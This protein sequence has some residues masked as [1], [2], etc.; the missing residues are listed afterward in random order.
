MIT[1]AC[2]GKGDSIK[3]ERGDPVE[4][5]DCITNLKDGFLF[6][7]RH[8]LHSQRVNPHLY[9]LERWK[10]SAGKRI[11]EISKL[12]DKSGALSWL[13]LDASN[14]NEKSF[15]LIL[16]DVK[17]GTCAKTIIEYLSA[18]FIKAYVLRMEMACY[19]L[20]DD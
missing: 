9:C 10:Q 14:V 15:E 20:L 2:S 16:S 1:N 13:T 4:F 5:Y 17:A 18:E 12:P 11:M 6:H 19:I 8:L 7:L 3:I